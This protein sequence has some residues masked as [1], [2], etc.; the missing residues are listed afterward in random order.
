ME[1]G[2]SLTTAD[3]TIGRSIPLGAQTTTLYELL[4]VEYNPWLARWTDGPTSPA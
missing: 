1:V 3:S 2:C 4:Q